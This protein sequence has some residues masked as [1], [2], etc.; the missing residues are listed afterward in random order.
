VF[1]VVVVVSGLCS[2]AWADDTTISFSGRI[3][4]SDTIRVD[5]DRATWTHNYWGWPVGVTFNGTSWDPQTSPQLIPGGT[6]I[7][8]SLSNYSVRVVSTEG[9]DVAVAEAKDD[10]LL[11]HLNDTPSGTDW[12]A[13][14]VVL[15]EKPPATRT[16]EATLDIEGRIDG[17]D[18]IRLTNTEATWIHKYYGT[19]TSFTLNDVAWNPSQQSTLANSGATQFLPDDI[20]L[21]TARLTKNAGRDLATLEIFSD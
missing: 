16:P 8:E 2:T 21:T 9:R 20:D 12:Y 10:H 13:F 19:P 6:L 15:T 18:R 11:I 3:D 17:S 4:G 14:D 5:A 7:P 1:L